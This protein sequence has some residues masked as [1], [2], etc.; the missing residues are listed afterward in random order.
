MV[1]RLAIPAIELHAESLE[2]GCEPVHNRMHSL[3][4]FPSVDNDCDQDQRESD[5]HP[6][7]QRDAQERDLLG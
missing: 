5:N 3:S 2:G 6:V 7:L 1:P 4:A